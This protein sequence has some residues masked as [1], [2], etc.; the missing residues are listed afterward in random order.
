MGRDPF[1]RRSWSTSS[2]FF[3]TELRR[4]GALH[5]AFGVEAP[6]LPR[7]GYIARNFKTD[8]E[9]W[10]TDFYNDAGYRDALTA[11]IGRRL[12]PGDFSQRF[13]QIGAMY[14]VPRLLEGRAECVSYHDGNLAETL[15]SPYAP[16]GLSVRKADIALAYERTVYHGMDRVYAMSEYLRRSFIDDFGVPAG[17]VVAVGA[18][19]NLDAMPEPVP[20]K[21]FDT[22]EVL[23]IGVDFAR[24]GGWGLLK[25]FQVVRERVSGATLHVVGPRELNVPPGLAGGVVMHGFLNKND[26]AERA[27][28]DGLFRRCGLF[29]MPSLYEPFGI[30]PLEAMAHQLPCLVTDA[31]ALREMVTPGET[32]D[33]VA[34][35]DVDDLADKLAALLADPEALRKMGEAGRKQVAERFTWDRVIDRILAEAPAD[36]P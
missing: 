32:G 2:Y 36:R 27:R 6:R 15:R 11:E 25:A 29:V 19:I 8:R 14:D 12:K 22:R 31:W 30:A 18:G 35:G 21:P 10:R 9:A 20:D 28:L 33:L 26:P 5:R 13:L 4:R 24:K 1:D 7:L 34:C 17:R 16:K 23:F 3:F